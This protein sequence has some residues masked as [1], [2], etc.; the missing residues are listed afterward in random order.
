MWIAIKWENSQVRSQERSMSKRSEI[1]HIKAARKML[2]SV[3]QSPLTLDER[4]DKAVELAAHIL[5]ASHRVITKEDRKRQFGLFRMKKDPVGKAFLTTMLD[6]CFRSRDHRRMANQIIYLLSLFGA[7]KFLGLFRRLKLRLCAVFGEKF[8][9]MITLMAMREL[10]SEAAKMMAFRGKNLLFRYIKSQKQR[11]IRV[12]LGDFRGASSGEQEA[13]QRL[14]AYLRDLENPWIDEISVT[15]SAIYSQ[16]NLLDYD[17]TLDTLATRLRTLY[18]AAIANKTKR[19]DGS[20]CF[21]LVILDIEAYRDV[22]LTKDV[23]MKVLSEPPFHL[24]SAGIVLQA[25]LPDVQKIQKELTEWATRRIENGGAPIKIRILK[26]GS[27]IVEQIE[28]SLHGWI[29]APYHHKVE[30][31]ANYRSMM[32]Y[33]CQSEHVRAVHIG[34]ATHNVF[35]IAFAML[36]RMEHGAEKEVTF[37]MLKGRANHT[38]DIVH[39]LTRALLLFCAPI[40]SRQLQSGIP[41][42][43]RRLDESV[44]ADTFSAHSFTLIPHSQEWKEQVLLFR[45]GCSMIGEVQQTPRR[46]QER[47][48]PVSEF[49]V[50]PFFENEPDIDT[51]LVSNQL[52]VKDVFRRWGRK[53]FEP[54]PLVIDGKHITRGVST[55]RGHDPSKTDQ[56]LYT[57]HLASWREIDQALA[58]AK[59]WESSWRQKPVAERCAVLS[60]VSQKLCE[61]RGD[62][63]GVMV[64]DGG[65]SIME[66]DVEHGEAVDSA[67]YYAHL[68]EHLSNFIDI[69]WTPKGTVCVLSPWNFPIS[70][71]CGSICSALVTGHCVLFKPAI[72][73][74]LAGWELVNIFWDAGIPKEVLQFIPCRDR[75]VHSQLIRDHRINQV[76]LTGATHTAHQLVQL[77]PNLDLCAETGGKNALIISALGDRDLAISNLI[78]SAFAHSGQKCNSVSLAILEKEVYE[79]PQ[80]R[81]QLRDAAQSLKVGSAWDLSSR[82]T[83]LVRAPS[84]DLTRGLT[85]LESGEFWLLKP[86]KLHSDAH[87]WSPGIKFGVRK[88]S[89]MH[90]TELLGPVLGVMCADHIEHAIELAN[91]TPYGLVSGLHSLDGREKRKWQKL[92][93]TGNGYINRDTTGRSVFRQPF[94][95]CKGSSYGR[96][97]KRGGPNYLVQLM[98][99]KQT[100][101]PKEKLP[102]GD[103]VNHLS[104]FLEKFDLSAEQLGIWYASVSSYAFF[105]QQFKRSKDPSKRVGQDNFLLYLSHKKLLFRIGPTVSPLDYLRVFA[106]AL[107]CETRL[108]VSWEKSP[109]AKR[110]NV[111]WETFLPIFS[112]VEEGEAAFIKRMHVGHVKRVRMLENPSEQIGEVATKTHTYIDHAPVCANGRIELLHYMREMT[113]SIDYHRYGSLGLRE[114]EMRSP[115]D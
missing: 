111:S 100:G 79:D 46:R 47:L 90:Q 112:I 64:A 108:E 48:T 45:S 81:R 19:A 105:Y 71:P 25:Y 27:M 24:L 17:N 102:L 39:V 62:L 68:M 57:Y 93:T 104:R 74:V 101:L 98:H 5:L 73:T 66:A 42:L 26:G 43:I 56:T 21:K 75:S 12:N 106:A 94:G 58:C 29:Q 31:D 88:G 35:D 2:N 69:G 34:V 49:H 53:Q 95:G 40:K 76:I 23:F 103:W 44:G 86:N 50:K 72:E 83:P 7:P 61:K 89:Y 28:A 38:Q 110:L 92:I 3:Y 18:Q 60:T 51:T 91:S 15:I 14:N 37:E 107:T 16:I 6:Q 13:E 54:I 84:E 8:P 20:V 115:V 65:K 78:E 36:L 59:R 85:T 33:G 1:E 99:A 11:G 55:G 82:V 80:F 97:Y 9:Q 10:K 114:N 96:G 77:R 87:L 52:F 70:I 67:K 63:I 22:R 32:L 4:R 41:Y 30:A 113:L 109:E